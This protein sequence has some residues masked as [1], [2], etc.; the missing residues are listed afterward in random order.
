MSV[1]GTLFNKIWNRHVVADLGEDFYLLYV[2]RHVIPDFN[3]SAF[4]RLRD[5][6]L[7]VRKPDL[8]FATADHSWDEYGGRFQVRIG[9]KEDRRY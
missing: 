2:D 3:G 5:R 1:D 7:K 6:G 9:Q 4:T 8:T